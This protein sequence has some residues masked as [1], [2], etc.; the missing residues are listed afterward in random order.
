M[1]GE[2]LPLA[3]LAR[4][5]FQVP[6]FVSLF[7]AVSMFSRLQKGRCGHQGRIYGSAMVSQR[8]R[9]GFASRRLEMPP[10]GNFV[11]VTPQAE[12]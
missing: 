1:C 8:F 5:R 7:A 2:C 11:C 9:N 10:Q 3:V 12:L 4:N 6:F